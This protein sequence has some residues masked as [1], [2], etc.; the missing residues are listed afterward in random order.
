[1]VSKKLP[2][3][4]QFLEGGEKNDALGKRNSANNR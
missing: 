1:V 3:M 4:S 2:K